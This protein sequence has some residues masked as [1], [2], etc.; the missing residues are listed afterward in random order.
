MTLNRDVVLWSKPL[1]AIPLLALCW[2]TAAQAQRLS[3]PS[4]LTDSLALARGMPVLA[5]RV[6]EQY[7][8]TDRARKLDNLFRL[9]IVAGRYDDAVRSLRELR[10]I[11]TL[12]TTAR[13]DARAANIQYEI[14]ARAM[15]TSARSGLSFNDAFATAFQQ[16]FATLDDRTSALV[17]RALSVAPQTLRAP[18]QRAVEQ[19]KGRTEIE[20]T[21]ALALVRAFQRFETHR[22][23]RPLV[24]AL[25]NEDDARRYFTERNVGVRTPDGATVCTQVMRP[26]AAPGK[27]TALLAFTIYV[28]SATDVSEMRRAAS[29]GYAGVS[30][31]TRG[32]ACS[33][34]TPVPYRYD[35]ADAAA[36]ID[37]IAAH[38]WSDGRVGMYGGSY[39]GF[40]T[41]AATKKMP[42]ALKAIMVG[43]PVAPGLDVPMEGNIVWSFIYQWPFYT[44]NN[45]TLDDTTYFNFPRWSKLTREWYV[46]G[47][48]YRDL[49]KIDGTPN[50]IFNEWISHPSY[51]AYW[52]QTI[53]YDEDFAKINIPVL[54]TA[55]YFYGGPGAAV[56][57]LNQHYAHD[58]QA[59]HYLV[60]GPY[61]HVPAQRGVVSALG[62][63]TTIFAGYTLD[64]VARID[65]VADLRYQW[66]DW[67]LRGGPRPPLLADRINYQVLGANEWKHAPS[68]AA[69]ANGR[70]RFYLSPARSGNAYRLA[71]ER[72]RTDTSVTLRVDLAYRR[73][74]DSSFAGGGVLDTAVN[75]YEA[76]KFVSDPIE[77]PAEVSGLYSGHLEF[78]TNKKDFDLSISLFEL[79]EKGEYFLLP[80]VQIR[81]SH[82]RDLET[83][84]L[85]TPGAR[86]AIDF[87]AIR[88]IS[89][90][91]RPRSRIVAV[92]GPIKWPGQQINYGSGKDVS[93]ETIADAGSP[94]EIRWFTNSFIDLPIRR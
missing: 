57:Y 33:P 8:D 15:A 69:M 18:L 3:L 45:K 79:T 52:Q 19:Q 47:R 67:T 35:G 42:K 90:R 61:D 59:R 75:T 70:L 10:S 28:D 43:A 4:P 84:R 94:L 49:D 46:S 53:P 63:T 82:A 34:Q 38:P 37:W 30:G 55:G 72:S 25:A 58:P 22:T 76:L 92:I 62:D 17:I 89:K 6:I 12:S 1:T 66:F 32:K 2:V 20:M 13:P 64:P 81:A 60:I 88:L 27:L 26:R 93:D 87:K 91:L 50:P 16:V 39:N 21:D 11:R 31:Y 85:L 40:T 71:S 86:E 24:T 74:I 83:R 80:P 23:F 73:D 44:T 29:N 56:Y 54:Q 14:W 5:T 9:Q 78:V 77:A 36:V 41:W 7:T 65:I 48:A 51:D 68:V